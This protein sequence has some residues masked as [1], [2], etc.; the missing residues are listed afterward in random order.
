M[1]TCWFH[2]RAGAIALA[3]GASAQPETCSEPCDDD[4]FSALATRFVPRPRREPRSLGVLQL[5]GYYWP[6]QPGDIS[7][8]RTF[9]TVQGTDGSDY[10]CKDP[11]MEGEDEF[12]LKAATV[13]GGTWSKVQNGSWD[14]DPELQDSFKRAVEHFLMDPSVHAIIGGAGWFT[15]YQYKVVQIMRD[16]V[17]ENRKKGISLK[18]KPWFGGTPAML[19]ALG[20]TILGLGDEGKKFETIKGWGLLGNSTDRLVFLTSNKA[21]EDCEFYARFLKAAGIKVKPGCNMTEMRQAMESA[22]GVDL[23]DDDEH[24]GGLVTFLHQMRDVFGDMECEHCLQKLMTTLAQ[25]IVVVPWQDTLGYGVAVTSPGALFHNVPAMVRGSPQAS[26]VIFQAIIRQLKQG[27]KVVGIIMESTEMPAYS[28]WV[29]KI[30]K[31]PVWDSTVVGKCLMATAPHYDSDAAEKVGNGPH[32][33]NTNEFRD[34]MMGWWNPTRWEPSAGLQKDGH[35]V[36][37]DELNLTVDQVMRLTC[38]GGR[39]SN[40]QAIGRLMSEFIPGFGGPK[41]I[42]AQCSTVTPCA[43]RTWVGMECLRDAVGGCI[44]G[45]TCPGGYFCGGDTPAQVRGLPPGPGSMSYIYGVR[46]ENFTSPLK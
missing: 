32:L 10:F 41:K 12:S 35:I 46:G 16:L 44:C 26:Q 37:Y 28:N 13:A 8:L 2:I 9:C 40:T 20:H 24:T 6:T 19:A 43:G 7:D 17:Q 42:P 25:K 4:S 5:D 3:L 30:T 18:M 39:V 22:W 1:R 23:E 36:L 11:K 38:V 14:G 15:W 27:F 31:L 33:F 21:L 45:G 34:C 29:R